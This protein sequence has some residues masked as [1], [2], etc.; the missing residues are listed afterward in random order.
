MTIQAARTAPLD[1][2]YYGVVVGVVTSNVDRLK[3]G[4]VRVRFP[5]FDDR[6]EAW[7]R[8][9]YVNAGKNVGL[10]APPE[11]DAEVLVAFEHGDM[12]SAFVLGGLYNGV[13]APATDRQDDATKDEKLLRTRSGHRLLFRDTDQHTEIVLQSAGGQKLTLHDPDDKGGA[14]L[15]AETQGGSRVEIDDRA[16][17]ITLSAGGATVTI[18]G[19]SGT[20]TLQA[21]T[22]NVSAGQVS[23]GIGASQRLVLGDAF[24]Q[25]FNLHVHNA[26]TPGAPTTPPTVPMLPVLLSA[27]TKTS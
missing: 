16:K 2:R 25:Y 14:K 22:V 20:V 21:K 27:T 10:F 17:K 8:V 11:K 1:R 4:R 18:D 15:T 13:D 6:T 23:L 7:C 5:W 12:R 19:A 26:T 9:V 24:M 3:Q